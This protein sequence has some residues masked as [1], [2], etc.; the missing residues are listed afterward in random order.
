MC[1]MRANAEKIT[2][3]AITDRISISGRAPNG[4]HNTSDAA[5][6]SQWTRS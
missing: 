1:H 6:M 2:F 5:I 4:K 3:N